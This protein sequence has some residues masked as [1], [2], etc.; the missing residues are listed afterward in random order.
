MIRVV[1]HKEGNGVS[2]LDYIALTGQI[3]T[4]NG[5]SIS[6]SLAVRPAARVRGSIDETRLEKC[7]RGT[8][9]LVWL[10][11]IPSILMLTVL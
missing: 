9:N 8:F 2:V 1:C 7:H 3:C 6:R 4:C 5:A 10:E 11:Y